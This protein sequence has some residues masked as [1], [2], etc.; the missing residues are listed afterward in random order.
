MGYHDHLWHKAEEKDMTKKGTLLLSLLYVGACASGPPALYVEAGLV[1][2]VDRSSDWM[3][4]SEREW[5]GDG[6]FV[7]GR[8]SLQWDHGI[9]C[10]ELSTRTRLFTGA[11]FNKEKVPEDMQQEMYNFD[12]ACFWTWGGK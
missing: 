10:P 12:V 3:L 7:E 9:K 1:H 6:A 4:R 11:P 8:I 5:N 2:Q